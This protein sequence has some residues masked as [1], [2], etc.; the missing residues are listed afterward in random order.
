VAAGSG[1]ALAIESIRPVPAIPFWGMAYRQ[2]LLI[3]LVEVGLF[4]SFVLA[5]VP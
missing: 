1:F 4:T 5:G 3:M 2:F